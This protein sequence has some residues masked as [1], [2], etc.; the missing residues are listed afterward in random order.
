MH[1]VHTTALKDRQCQ[2][3]RRCRSAKRQFA[4][5]CGAYGFCTHNKHP[6]MEAQVQFC[7]TAEQ[8]DALQSLSLHDCID[9]WQAKLCSMCS[10][11]MGYKGAPPNNGRD[12]RL[13]MPPLVGLIT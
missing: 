8:T 13:L 1:A 6:G 12:Q 5:V 11:E 4:N 10:M 9:T 3:L 7:T 2:L